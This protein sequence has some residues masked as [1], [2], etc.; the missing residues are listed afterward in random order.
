MKFTILI[1]LIITFSYSVRVNIG[2]SLQMNNVVIDMFKDKNVGV[3]TAAGDRSDSTALIRAMIQRGAKK[4]EWIPIKQPCRNLVRDPKMVELINTYDYIYF[5][6]GSPSSLHSCLYGDTNSPKESTP[7]LD[8]IK[9]KELI[10]GSSAGSL[11][12]PK[13]AILTTGFPSSYE[14]LRTGQM[15]YSVNGTEILRENGKIII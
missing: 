15:A 11:V 9:K 2:G 13:L 6:G 7:V 3:I 14:T 10:A 1:F 8:A 5:T 4:A 12:Q